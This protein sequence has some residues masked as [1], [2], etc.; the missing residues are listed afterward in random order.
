MA[1]SHADMTWPCEAYGPELIA[2][3]ALCFVAEAGQR[4][5]SAPQQCAE[6]V[7]AERKRIFRRVQEL[8]AAG[9][10]HGEAYAYLESVFASPEDL[11]AGPA[12]AT[13]EGAG[14]E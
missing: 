11:L 2:R 12:T 6:T 13:D 4:H 7:D 3:G 9:G 8:S 10:P 1:E 5:C 14:G